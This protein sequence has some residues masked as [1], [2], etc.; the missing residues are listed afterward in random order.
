M[1]VQLAMTNLDAGLDEIRE[2]PRDIG[3]LELIVARPVDEQRERR[4]LQNSV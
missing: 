2:S 3:T 1:T 4:T